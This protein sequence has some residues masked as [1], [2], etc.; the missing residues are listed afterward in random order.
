MSITATRDDFP[1]ISYSN[2]SAFASI[3]QFYLLLEP[4]LIASIQR[5]DIEEARRLINHVL[6]HIYSLGEGGSDFLK[7]LLL[8]FVVILSRRAIEAGADSRAVLDTGFLAA[9]ELTS[10]QD[11]EDLARWL[12]KTLDALISIFPKQISLPPVV[13]RALKYM[14]ERCDE[15][16]RREVVARACGVSDSHLNELFKQSM[17]RP[18][19]EI[20]RRIRVEKAAEMLSNQQ[21]DL[22]DVAAAC[23]FCDQSHLTRVFREVRGI[24]PKDFR[25]RV[26]GVC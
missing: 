10:A 26:R 22:A 19:R 15:P 16:I 5:E 8:E 11:D 4:D 6:V 7:F 12:R 21:A 2:G 3:H 23:G 18:F 1:A 13:E 24:T 20:L 17:G 25:N 9:T 14:R